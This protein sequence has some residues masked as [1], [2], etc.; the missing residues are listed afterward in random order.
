MQLY[1]LSTISNSNWTIQSH[2]NLLCP[3]KLVWVWF[4]QISVCRSSFVANMRRGTKRACKSIL[5]MTK[6]MIQWVPYPVNLLVVVFVLLWCYCCCDV[7]GV[8]MFV[9]VVMLLLLWYAQRWHETLLFGAWATFEFISDHICHFPDLWNMTIWCAL[10]RMATQLSEATYDFIFKRLQ[11]GC[12]GS[13]ALNYISLYISGMGNIDID[14][15][16]RNPN[17][18]M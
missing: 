1:K 17:M 9:L 6:M 18:N 15:Q 2:N 8:V 14:V 13:I 4:D 10:N 11:E 7:I 5:V 3:K 12:V 16:H